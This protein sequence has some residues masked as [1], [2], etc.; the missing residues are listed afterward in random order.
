MNTIQEGSSSIK[1][2]Y[3]PLSERTPIQ[4]T[5]EHRLSDELRDKIIIS[6]RGRE[7]LS[8]EKSLLGNMDMKLPLLIFHPMNTR[9]FKMSDDIEYPS[10]P[11]LFEGRH[12]FLDD[13]IDKKITELEKVAMGE[14]E[15]GNAISLLDSVKNAIEA[16]ANIFLSFDSVALAN[17]SIEVARETITYSDISDELASSLHQLLDDTVTSQRNEQS[18]EIKELKSYLSNNS[19][20]ADIIK[21]QMILASAAMKFNDQLQS[22]TISFT[23]PL[24]T[25]SESK[26]ADLLLKN[27]ELVKFGR[28]KVGEMLDFYEHRFEDHMVIVEGNSARISE[29]LKSEIQ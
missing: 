14:M 13:S 27:T 1:K 23:D 28:D 22:S 19:S 15:E 11:T 26:I 21:K 2:Q 25:N 29:Y 18:N 20:Y 4:I 7:L 17:Y 8:D 24:S 6:P 5:E 9:A 10:R 16:S 3:L 12:A